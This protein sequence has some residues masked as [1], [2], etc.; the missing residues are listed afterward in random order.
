MPVRHAPIDACQQH[1]LPNTTDSYMLCMSSAVENVASV[2]TTRSSTLNTATCFTLLAPQR[3]NR[4]LEKEAKTRYYYCA[5]VVLVLILR[6]VVSTR[7]L[8]VLRVLI[9]IY[10][11]IYYIDDVILRIKFLDAVT[12][13]P[14]CKSLAV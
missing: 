5:N 1:C 9:C 2:V 3:L 4:Q 8:A 7:V 14:I 12:I 13:V 10:D 11:V 6:C